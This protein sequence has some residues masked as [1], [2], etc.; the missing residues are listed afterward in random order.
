[1]KIYLIRHGETIGEVQS[2]YKT[3]IMNISQEKEHNFK[4]ILYSGLR[5]L[6]WVAA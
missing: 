5:K 4:S 1:M 3:Y 6:K 2:I